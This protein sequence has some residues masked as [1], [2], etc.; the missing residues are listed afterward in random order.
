MDV[1]LDQQI[2]E[3]ILAFGALADECAYARPYR[4]S[5]ERCAAFTTWLHT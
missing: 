1:D 5:T 4:T 3:K 2:V